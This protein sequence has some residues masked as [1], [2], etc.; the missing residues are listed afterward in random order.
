MPRLGSGYA[1]LPV[2]GPGALVNGLRIGSLVELLSGEAGQQELNGRLGQLVSY[3]E[4]VGLF[5]VCL[6]D[7][8]IRQVAAEQV[9][10]LEDFRRPGLGGGAESFDL[11]VG[12]RHRQDV[13]AE[14][15][16]AC[17]LEKGF[18]VLKVCQKQEDVDRAVSSVRHLGATGKLQRL[19]EELEE[20]Y[21]GLGARARVAWMDGRPLDRTLQAND[22]FM[23]TIAALLQPYCLDVLGKVVDSRT[24]A[25]V[26]LSLD[27]EGDSEF[28]PEAADDAALGT[29]LSTWR[30]SQLRILHCMGP[31]TAKVT[32]DS[33]DDRDYGVDESKVN[34]VPCKVDSVEISATPNTLVV[35]RTGIFDLQC[36]TEEDTLCLSTS[37]LEHVDELALSSDEVGDLDWLRCVE[38]PDGPDGEAV[39]VVN[40]STRLMAKWDEPEAYRAG[41][42]GGCDA[43]IE[44]P[45]TRWDVHAYYNP[46]L[47]LLGPS[48]TATMHQSYVEGIELFDNKYFEIHNNEAKTMDPMQR[49][50]LE[51]GAQNLFKL[52]IDKKFSNRNPHHAGVSVG[53]DKDDWDLIPKPPELQGGINVQAIIAN[54]FSFTFNLRGPNFVADTACSAS[55]TATHL[56]KLMLQDRTVDK[57]EFHIAIGIHQCLAPHAFIGAS[58]SHMLSPLGRCLTFNSSASGYARGDGC[59]GLTLKWGHLPDERDAVWRASMVGQNGKSATL[60]APNGLSQED[61]IWRA[62]REAKISPS[63]SCVW[64]C[65]GTGTSLGDPIE[66]GAVRK[67]MSKSERSTALLLVTNKTHTGHLEGGAAMTSLLAAAFQVKQACAIP[68][69]HF[70]QL[71]PHLEHSNFDAQITN[72]LTSYNYSQGHVHVSSFGFGGTN[73]HAIFWG[74]NV[75]DAP[76]VRELFQ[77]R[78]QRMSPPEV[79]VNGSDVWL[80]EWDGPDKDIIAGDKYTIEMNPEDPP[81]ASQR[82]FKEECGAAPDDG[83]DDKY[84]ITGPFNEWDI[85]VMEDG[86]V[87]GLRTITVTVPYSGAVEFRFLKNGREDEIIYPESDKCSRRLMPILGPAKHDGGREQHTWLA[88]GIPGSQM[89]ISFFICRGKRSI[90]WCAEIYERLFKAHA[91]MAQSGQHEVIWGIG[92]VRWRTTRVTLRH[93]AI[94]VPV[95]VELLPDGTFQVGPSGEPPSLFWGALREAS[96]LAVLAFQDIEAELQSGGQSAG[97]ATPSGSPAA[98][99]ARQSLLQAIATQLHPRC[100][101]VVAGTAALMPLA[102]HRGRAG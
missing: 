6:V 50:V 87:T 67:I 28:P 63:T 42:F 70:R 24:P 91:R 83:L 27:N 51:V 81:N 76:N 3:E 94:L 98:V 8:S 55:L 49:H 89:N 58:Q 88:E 35:F 43:S 23:S 62:C 40:L 1:E 19:S 54:R 16:G 59:S 34:C 57:L 86:L 9:R 2:P 46:D 48:Q 82:W 10:T 11:L 5:R 77:K 30:R 32:L 99:T 39:N 66:V 31:G 68:I 75:Y 33:K 95:K 13:L 12:P 69:I 64:S 97:G 90:T 74:E 44:I 18:C 25:L 85:E 45:L 53:L 100:T 47:A 71:N 96:V 41:L 38:G 14:E 101:V 78:L 65:H 29:F 80:W 4:Q 17:L 84:Y 20:G 52:G 79:R 7:G 26:S 93:P 22:D 15:M 56:G 72:E 61:V 37:V 92:E 21:L 73:A 102:A 36:L 60:T